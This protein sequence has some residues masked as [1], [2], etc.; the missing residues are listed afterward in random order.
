MYT[1]ADNNLIRDL[2]SKLLPQKQYDSELLVSMEHPY[3]LNN[4]DNAQRFLQYTLADAK[5]EEDFFHFC[6][7]SKP[8]LDVERKQL[9]T[10][11]L[12]YLQAP[13]PDQELFKLLPCF[14]QFLMGPFPHKFSANIGSAGT[15]K[16]TS[17]ANMVIKRNNITF[18]AATNPA[19]G[20]F[21]TQVE[22]NVKPGSYQH[23]TKETVHK[24]TGINLED[25]YMKDCLL[26]LES[27]KELHDSYNKLTKDTTSPD[28]KADIQSDIQ[29][30]IKIVLKALHPLIVLITAKLQHVFQYYQ[31]HFRLEITDK[32][33]PYYQSTDEQFPII[34]EQRAKNES[35]FT[36]SGLCNCVK[37]QDGYISYVLQSCNKKSILPYNGYH[38][39]NILTLVN[40]IVIDEAGRLPAYFNILICFIWWF[41]QFLYN[42][43]ML[44]ETIPIISP[45]GSDS[46]SNV[47][48]FPIS[49]LD[50]AILALFIQNAEMVLAYIAEH[51]RRKINSFTDLK[52]AMHNTACLALEKFQINE[53]TYKPFMFSETFPKLVDDPRFRPNAI[54]MYALHEDVRGF[55]DKIHT[56]GNANIVTRDSIFISSDISSLD[57]GTL[58]NDIDTEELST[59][60]NEEAQLRRFNMWKSKKYIYSSGYVIKDKLYEQKFTCHNAIVQDSH[61]SSDVEES[62]SDMYDNLKT[63]RRTE[64]PKSLKRR[65]GQMM[66]EEEL[67]DLEYR[68][69]MKKELRENR[70]KTDDHDI[71]FICGPAK[72]MLSAEEHRIKR[73]HAKGIAQEL[74][75]GLQL[76]KT[77]YSSSTA[78]GQTTKMVYDPKY[79]ICIEVANPDYSGNDQVLQNSINETTNSRTLY[80][81]ISRERYFTEN[82]NVVVG[83]H[84]M[85]VIL[86]GVNG[87]VQDIIHSE[88]FLSSHLSF[89]LLA[90][91]GIL[92]EY[93]KWV[94]ANVCKHTNIDVYNIDRQHITFL[95]K[96]LDLSENEK[97][98]IKN[99]E[100][101]I[102]KACDVT[103]LE[104]KHV[105]KGQTL[106]NSATLHDSLKQLVVKSL[107][108]S[109]EFGKKRMKFY[110]ENCELL[111]TW[112]F[113]LHEAT[114][115]ISL[116]TAQYKL[117]GDLIIIGPGNHACNSKTLGH[118]ICTKI[119]RYPCHAWEKKMIGIKN[120]HL[121]VNNAIH[122]L[123]PDL[124][125]STSTTL[126]LKNIVIA[127]VYPSVLHKHVDVFDILFPDKK[128]K[129]N[130][131][132]YGLMLRHTPGNLRQPKSNLL[133]KI[134][135]L[136]GGEC[137]NFP[138]PFKINGT[139]RH[140][141]II[142]KKG[143]SSFFPF[144]SLVE[145][146]SF[147][148]NRNVESV[149][150]FA[151]MNPIFTRGAST[152]DYMQGKT[153]SGESMVNFKKMTGP[154]QLVAVTRNDS[155]HNLLTS[156]VTAAIEKTQLEKPISIQQKLMIKKMISNFFLF[157]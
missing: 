57:D 75:H 149:A 60:S 125:A 123:F 96:T 9:F 6:E 139:N 28:N 36:D 100:E 13:V 71:R 87:S 35:K 27:N 3:S 66:S 86:R 82:S 58:T 143:K 2:E 84:K 97:G 112:G 95:G 21:V 150:C 157:R 138:R 12:Q 74:G 88:C 19:F 64:K 146:E 69:I 134:F 76:S 50:E 73:M 4:K 113:L 127:N 10:F 132:K 144:S 72:E 20:T 78:Q 17:S 33:H 54:R 98:I 7:K 128:G 67:E 53:L 24:L 26:R 31:T 103:C 85:S 120:M 68:E 119:R 136:N 151:L 129:S 137:M 22:Q 94:Y 40:V 102:L 49:M 56:N 51:N 25:S 117:E 148:V 14:D 48:N 106:L 142:L 105:N 114:R 1:D 44:Y 93:R 81:C 18:C 52:T 65:F 145:S 153:I 46:Q 115:P 133:H 99:Y 152:V 77:Y 101:I 140:S 92:E 121:I 61:F 11:M 41:S 155:S 109:T 39:P 42:T 154:K 55:V 37:N 62:I 34:Q 79:D 70:N 43:P 38:T 111:N 122:R 118:L 126:L 135:H 83:S 110:I 124:V 16:T 8:I 30:H 90:Y 15:G 32:S 23:V 47:I 116:K 107:H 29:D 131:P 63:F 147:F 91:C 104:F 130:A 141:N 108:T 80:M 59:L 45:S 5:F 156:N 89:R